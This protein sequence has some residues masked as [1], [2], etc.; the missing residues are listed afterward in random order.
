MRNMSNFIVAQHWTN[1]DHLIVFIF[2]HLGLDGIKNPNRSTMCEC[3]VMYM[4]RKILVTSFRQHGVWYCIVFVQQMIIKHR[5]CLILPIYRI[6]F[7]YCSI[8]FMQCG[9]CIPSSEHFPIVHIVILSLDWLTN[10]SFRADDA[11]ALNDRALKASKSQNQEG[12]R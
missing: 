7:S 10:K 11:F 2:N 9:V 4:W 3:T 12:S 5:N 1:F 8:P 6:Q